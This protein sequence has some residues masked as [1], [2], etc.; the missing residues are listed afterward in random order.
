MSNAAK[1]VERMRHNP[2]DWRIGSV[3]TVAKAFGFDVR[4]GATSHVTL[5]HSKLQEILT[6]PAKKPVKPYYIRRLVEL[7][8]QVVCP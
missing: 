8:D 5:S 2:L 6:I 1:I 4:K 7:V 3:E